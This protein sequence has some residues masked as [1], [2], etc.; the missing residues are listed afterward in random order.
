MFKINKL[1]V[2]KRADDA[3]KPPHTQTSGRLC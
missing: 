1:C 3:D 2:L